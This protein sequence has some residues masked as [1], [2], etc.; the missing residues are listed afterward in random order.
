MRDRTVML[1]ELLQQGDELLFVGRRHARARLD[2]TLR[3]AHTLDY[4]LTGRE[5]SGG[6]LWERLARR[7]AAG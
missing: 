7:K 2:L 1:V 6:W 5:S 4:V 3:N